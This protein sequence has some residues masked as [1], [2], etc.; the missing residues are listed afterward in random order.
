MNNHF[1]I[2]KTP[3]QIEWDDM[4]KVLDIVGLWHYT[5][6]IPNKDCYEINEVNRAEGD[7]LEI[8]TIIRCPRTAAFF[9]FSHDWKAMYSYL[10]RETGKIKDKRPTEGQLYSAFEYI[11]CLL[12]IGAIEFIK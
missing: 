4:L 5:R 1:K 3:S 9:K 7:K 6:T 12:E 2:I 8:Q 10:D 11:N